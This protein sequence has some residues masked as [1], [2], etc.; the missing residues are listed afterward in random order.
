MLSR[1]PGPSV[2]CTCRA[3]STIPYA[4]FSAWFTPEVS[5]SWYL[6]WLMTMLSDSPDL[7]F[8]FPDGVLHHACPECTALCCRGQGFAGSAKREMNFIFKNYPQFGGM[9]QER[10]GDVVTCATPM[11]RCFFLRDDNLCQI[12]VT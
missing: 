11:G 6:D 10:E 4:G 8:A 5:H 9:V 7:Y 2:R 3:A 1:N 12:E